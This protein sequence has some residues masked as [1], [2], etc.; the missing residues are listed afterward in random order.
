MFKWKWY[1]HTLS[2]CAEGEASGEPEGTRYKHL[3]GKGCQEWRPDATN[4]NFAENPSI[5]LSTPPMIEIFF[6]GWGWEVVLIAS[7][8]PFQTMRQLPFTC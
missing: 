5:L 6:V 8:L 1:H 4:V 7:H 2:Y 3:C